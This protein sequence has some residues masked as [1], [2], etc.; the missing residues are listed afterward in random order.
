MK[1]R[2]RRRVA[3]LALAA[4]TA[5]ALGCANAVDHSLNHLPGGDVAA[6]GLDGIVDTGAG[7]GAN[8][9]ADVAVGADAAADA[10]ADAL[11]AACAAPSCAPVDSWY[12]FTV[13]AADALDGD[14]DSPIIDQLNDQLWKPDIAKGELNILMHVTKR[15]ADAIE[16]EVRNGAR[17]GTDGS[18]CVLPAVNPPVTL[19]LDGC[20]VHSSTN[21]TLLIY[22]GSREFP[23]VCA[24]SVQPQANS[25]PVAEVVLDGAL[26][27]SCNTVEA[28]ATGMI[29][30]DVLKVACTC[31]TF[32]KPDDFSEACGPIAPDAAP[33][34]DDPDDPCRGCGGDAHQFLN[35]Y[36]AFKLFGGAG[37]L[38]QCQTASGDKAVCVEA[39]VRAE[40][41]DPPPPCP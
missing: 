38:G 16:V 30:V 26:D 29:V 8:V 1:Y 6:D 15:T 5:P 37:E 21:T 35:L 34:S 13:L 11:A 2:T 33:S 25:V 32:L 36:N 12:R 14:P 19:S 7:D 28:S 9:P 20:S 27:E 4:L 41:V 22:A 10:G 31:G 39:H 3:A 24:P 18:Y 17:T 23:K 40:R